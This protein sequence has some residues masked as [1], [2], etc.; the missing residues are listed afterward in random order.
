MTSPEAIKR[1][2]ETG[3]KLIK[4]IVFS[5]PFHFLAWTAVAVVFASG[6]LGEILRKYTITWLAPEASKHAK[7]FA[8]AADATIDTLNIIRVVVSETRALIMTL[9]HG[10]SASA[11][12][13]A[14]KWAKISG[15]QVVDAAMRV[16]ACSSFAVPDA[17]EYLIKD[18]A[19]SKVCP[20]LR[21]IKP[22]PYINNT[23]PLLEWLSYDPEPY[24]GNNCLP[25]EYVY[26]V[27]PQLCTALQAGGIILE[28]ALPFL[29][30]AVFL[31][32]CGSE[33]VRF[34]AALAWAVYEGAK[35]VAEKIHKIAV[36][37][38]DA[39]FH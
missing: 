20:V 28:V 21:S 27:E 26:G 12:I 17:I 15:A 4:K 39:A 35:K 24:P 9:I 7:A 32:V 16:Q 31:M 34:V 36:R 11:S 10:S 25:I 37:V 1:L 6:L 2:E 18:A 8:I 14:F 13:P 22:I 23:I 19:S 33:L 5:L 3:E 29:I 38:V 30:S